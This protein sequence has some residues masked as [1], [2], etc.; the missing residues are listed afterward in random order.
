MATP[1]DAATR[2]LGSLVADSAMTANTTCP[3]FMSERP[4]S[5]STSSQWGGKIELTRTRLK[6]ARCASRSAISK[7][8][9]FSLCRPTPL[10]RKALVGTNIRDSIDPSPRARY[11][12]RLLTGAAQ[13]IDL[14]PVVVGPELHLLR[15]QGN[16]PLEPIVRELR[17][18]AARRTDTMLVRLPGR[19]RLVPLEPLAKVVLLGQPGADQQV[20]CPIDRGRP[21]RDPLGHAPAHLLGRQ[22]LAGEEHRLGHRQP[23][24]RRRQVVLGQVAAEFLEELG[25]VNLHT[26]PP[27]R[28]PRAARDL[29]SA[30]RCGMKEIGRAHV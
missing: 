6:L 23:L 5:R 15:E 10:V 14:Q 29:R 22:V 18:L 17:H 27:D 9:S 1:I 19:E 20:E 21:D 28:P 24:L 7:L 16:H 4:S 2:R 12:V 3:G 8:V 13:S 25:P 11:R 26:T 30:R